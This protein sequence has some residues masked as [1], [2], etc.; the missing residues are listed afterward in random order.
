[1]HIRDALALIGPAVPRAV[2]TWADLGAGS[3]MF[4]AAL[5]EI[6]EP[7]SRVHAIDRDEAAV[8][9]LR[10]LRVK[11]GVTITPMAADF[12]GDGPLPGIGVG[13]LAGL[14]FAN[15]LHFVPD[16]AAVLT[17]L[18]ELLER[19]GRV[20]IIEYDRRPASRW[21]PYPIPQE[22]LPALASAAGLTGFTV[23]ATRPSRFSG[24]LYAASAV[25]AG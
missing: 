16:A 15:S 7:G 4:T 8:A 18:V 10:G 1:M 3:G 14:L 2:A 20:V 21:V 13:T 24:M 6:L 12:A 9:S 19:G 23:V 11:T 5:A 25:R 22:V 17:R